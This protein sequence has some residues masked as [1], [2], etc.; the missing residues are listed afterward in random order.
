[1]KAAADAIVEGLGG[2]VRSGM[3]C[4]PAHDDHTPSLHIQ[5]VHGKVL[6]YCFAGCGQEA[7]LDA[8][9]DRGLW[10]VPGTAKPSVPTVRRSDE[11]RRRYALEIISNTRANRGRVLVVEDRVLDEYFLNRGIKTVPATALFALPYNLDRYICA[12]LVPDCPAM[13]FEIVDGH[14]FVGAHVTWLRWDLAGKRDQEPTRQFF[15]TVSGGY[16][17]LYEGD[18]TPTAKLIIAEGVENA[19]SAAQIAGGV[20]AIAALSAMNMPKITP[21]RAAEYIV[22]ADHD[23]AG[24][25]GARELACR[26]V[27][28]GAIVRLAIPPRPGSDWNDFLL[29]MK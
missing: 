28:A 13:V 12:R 21:P 3:A 27:R 29:E 20:P 22:A 4:C 6:V 14:Q 1:L 5:E 24:L 9:R 25:R 16:I 17:K 26:L 19:M 7:V 23:D 11:E 10:P 8:L 18:L 2:D 15:G